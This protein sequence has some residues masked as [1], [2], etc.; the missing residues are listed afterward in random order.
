MTTTAAV[1]RP[2]PAEV[3][4][5]VSDPRL[6]IRW[7][8]RVEYR[9]ALALQ[10]ALFATS[11]GNHLLLLEHAHVFTVGARGDMSNLLVDPKVLG[12]EVVAV[13]R[14]GDITYHGPGQLV[15]YPILSITGKR[16]GGMIDTA[17][18]VH[19][20]EQLAIDSLA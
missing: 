5:K 13:D 20:V 9:D 7:L 12:A 19:A 1:A 4:A 14:G 10:H 15:G 11:T 6:A 3:R 2:A 16:G 8:G 17:E 18:Y